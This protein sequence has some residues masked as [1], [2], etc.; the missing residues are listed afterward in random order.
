MTASTLAFDGSGIDGSWYLDTTDFARHTSWLNGA[1]AAYSSVGITLFAILIVIAWWTARRADAAAMTAALA[2]PVAAVAAYLV[3]D[4]VK[5]II[6]ERRPCFAFPNAFLL[7]KCP[8]ATDYSFPSNHTVVAAALTAALFL[9]S[10][11]F[12]FI[13]AVATAVMG[14]SRV[15]VGAHYPHD[16]AAGLVVGVVVGFATAVALRKYATP[17]IDKLSTGPLRP[18]LAA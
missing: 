1:M 13:A 8:P 11:R 18:V 16:V 9:I 7:E 4:A 15:Y 12:G 3:N 14:W 10:R 17:L 2:V 5:S 6:A